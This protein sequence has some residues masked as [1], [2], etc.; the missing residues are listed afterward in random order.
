LSQ[1]L[2]GVCQWGPFFY[3]RIAKFLNYAEGIIADNPSLRPVKKAQN[4]V[5]NHRERIIA[6]WGNDYT[7][8]LL[9]GLNGLFQAAR[10]R[11]P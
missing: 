1:G 4:T 9:K 3:E 8:A 7:N 11:S 5:K 6:I 10:V 2:H